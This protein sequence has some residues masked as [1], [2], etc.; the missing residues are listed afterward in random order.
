MRRKTTLSLI[1][2]FLLVL[3]FSNLNAQT[4]GKI[5]GMV[6]DGS[7][8]EPL[9]GAN[10]IIEG[11]NLGASVGLDGSFYII[12]IQPGNY[13]VSVQM[14]GYETVQVENVQ[15]SV[16]RT[17]YLDLT[18]NPAIMEGEVIVVQASKISTKKDQTSSMRTVSSEQLDIL[19]IENLGGVVAMQA[20]VVNGHFR[21]GR[22]NEVSYMIDGLQVDDAFSGEGRTVELETE[23]I[24]DLEV[25]TGTFNAE[26]GRAMSGVVNAVTKDGGDRYSASF[27]SSFG[28]YLTSH[29][30]IFIGLDNSDINRNQDYKFQVSGPILKNKLSFF[31]NTRLQDNKNHLNGIRRFRVGD[32]SDFAAGNFFSIFDPEN[33]WGYSEHTGDGSYVPMNRSEN[34]SILGKLSYKMFNNLRLSFLYSRNDDEWHSYDHSY[35]YNPDGRAYAR[36]NSDLYLFQLNHTISQSA[37]YELKLSYLN[38]YDGWYLYEDPR[39]ERYIGDAYHGNSG[40]TGFWTG[41]Q[42]KEHS[43]TYQKDFNTKFDFTWQISSKHLIK[44]GLLYTRHNL[45]NEWHEIRNL[46][47]DDEELA[48]YWEFNQDGEVS[49]PNYVASIAADTTRYADVYDVKPIE[50]SAFIQDK[51]EYEDMVINLGLR[52]D[53]FD[54]STVYPSNRRNPDANPLYQTN[55]TTKTEY[56]DADTKIQI[57]PRLGLAYQLG[58]KAVLHFS[59][60]H[61]FQMP[62]MSALYTNNSF[63]YWRPDH[64]ATMGNSQIKAQKTVKYEIGLG[65]ELMKGI[66]LDIVLFYSDIYDLQSAIVETAYNQ[67]RY[68]L[69]SNKDYGNAKGLEFK[70]DMNYGSLYSY[71]NYTLQYT[72]G[73]ADNPTQTFNRAGGNIDPVNKL[74]PMSWDQRHTLNLT[75]GYAKPN[76]GLTMTS[77]YNSGAPYT[78]SPITKNIQ[79]RVNLYPNNDYRP[80]RY[81]VDLS[82]FYN[83]RVFEDFEL[84]ITLNVYNLLDRLNE[85][86]VYGSTGRAYTDVIEDSDLGN[87]RSDFNDY[88][89]RIKNPDAYS[90]PR[91]VKLGFG[92]AF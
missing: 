33:P 61:F 6:S 27:S 66:W 52:M 8:N 44:T 48:N 71:L 17:S 56:L 10:V 79:S 11:G 43:E 60:G 18:L 88:E 68:G 54:P 34:L 19:P 7:N 87:H 74:I 38:N 36:R 47:V 24:Q 81:T 29:D 3:L 45:I 50:F 25:I 35:K 28:N 76:Y 89:D 1:L 26:Y 69:Y 64:S 86:W 46:Y 77:Y 5:A 23:S 63:L 84:R 16:N 90:A 78:W 67:T 30:D 85:Q 21:G 55:E 2:T 51:M 73:N 20:G 62:P 22:S 49:Y 32:F 91:L 83:L 12:N 92:V 31:L 37:F 70:V 80:S 15:V 53:Y 72:R 57:S 59:Y 82:G 9:A 75:V 4:T 39:D 14:I 41:G 40:E 58:N 42:D 13:V 65:Q